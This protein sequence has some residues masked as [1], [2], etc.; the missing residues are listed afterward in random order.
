[1]IFRRTGSTGDFFPTKVIKAIS[2]ESI[3]HTFGRITRWIQY[4][5]NRIYRGKYRGK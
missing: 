4:E 3:H 1:M 2:Q 5:F